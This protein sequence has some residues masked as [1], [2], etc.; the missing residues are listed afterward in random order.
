MYDD[1]QHHGRQSAGYKKHAFPV[2]GETLTFISPADSR[3]AMALPVGMA[4]Q[5][6]AAYAQIERMLDGM[7][8]SLADVVQIVEFVSPAGIERYAENIEIRDGFFGGRPP[9]VNTVPVFKLLSPDALIQIEVTVGGK[10]EGRSDEARW[11]GP[12]GIIFLPTVLPLGDDGNIAFPGDVVGQTDQILIN[13]EKMLRSLGSDL[14]HV[15]MT[16]DQIVTTARKDY[17]RSGDVRKARLGPVYP[18]AAG[19]MQK[20]L[21]HPDA[22]VQY[23]IVATRETPERIDPGWERYNELSYS[24]GVKAGKYVFPS[25]QVAMDPVTMEKQFKDDIVAQSEYIYHNILKVLAAAGGRPENIVRVVE[26]AEDRSFA[27]YSGVQG[28]RAKLL[29][30]RQPH[31]SGVVCGGLLLPEV[32]LEVV[33]FAILD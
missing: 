15:A 1:A 16:I 10:L 30:G 12:S 22:L 13:A 9:A 7:G 29:P 25:G 18:G 23:D 17:K 33:L 24:A 19:I 21:V 27:N 4:A 14:S 6:R 26:F 20:R 3:T 11:D 2:A 31:V 5:V 32:E 8:R 28:V